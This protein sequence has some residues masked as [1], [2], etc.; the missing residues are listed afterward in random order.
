MGRGI[1][2]C[3][4]AGPSSVRKNAALSLCRMELSASNPER[5]AEERWNEVSSG[6]VGACAE[7][8]E[9]S[10]GSVGATW[11]GGGGG[12]GAGGGLRQVFVRSCASGPRDSY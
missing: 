4:A 6:S 2:S 10:G 11:G 9:A 12:G 1:G 3:S 8:L 5:R 7:M